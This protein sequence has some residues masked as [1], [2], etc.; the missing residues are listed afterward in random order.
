M[1][2]EARRPALAVDI[3][4]ASA[5]TAVTSPQTPER[6]VVTRLTRFLLCSPRGTKRAKAS[7]GRMVDEA[8]RPAR[9]VELPAA[10]AAARTRPVIPTGRASVAILAKAL[11]A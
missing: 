2:D 10:S 4:A 1:V 6:R 8:R 9:A 11:S 7:L 5:A 3:T